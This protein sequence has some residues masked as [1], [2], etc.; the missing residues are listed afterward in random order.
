MVEDAWL[1]DV[2]EENPTLPGT[3]AVFA[4]TLADPAYLPL[5]D[6]YTA[7]LDDEHQYLQEK[8]IV[9]FVAQ[10]GIT[11]A[12][13]PRYLALL[14]T[15]QEPKHHRSYREA[16]A[17]PAALRLLLDHKPAHDSY[18]WPIILGATFGPVSK[19]RTLLHKADAT[20]RQLYTDLFAEVV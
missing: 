12:T 2:D 5:L 11:A 10:Y 8:F 1:L 6:R 7:L 9:A 14:L 19:Q 13:L 16:F 20:T 4:L 15:L 18:T 17:D 3:F